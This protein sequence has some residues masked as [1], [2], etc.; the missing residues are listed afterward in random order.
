M[1]NSI[2]SVTPVTKNRCVGTRVCVHIHREIAKR[3]FTSILR[4]VILWWRNSMLLFLC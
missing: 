4:V 1:E 3:V 2:Y